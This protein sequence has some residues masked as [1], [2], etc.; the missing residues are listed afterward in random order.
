M[1]LAELMYNSKYYQG[2]HDPRQPNGRMLNIQDYGNALIKKA[3][4]FSS[5][6]RGEQ[7]VEVVEA[8]KKLNELGYRP[9]LMVDGIMGPKTLLAIKWFQS[10]NGLKVDG[11]LGPKTWEKLKYEVDGPPTVRNLP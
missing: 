7:V 9:P 1:Q 2:F 8:Q 11:I 3:A 5:A 6:L 4:L 10:H